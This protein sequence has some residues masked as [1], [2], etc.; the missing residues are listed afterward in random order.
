[1][2]EALM[3]T[4]NPYDGPRI[5]GSVGPA[6]PGVSVRVVAEGGLPA[7]T[8]EPGV[9][10]MTGPNLFSGYW[11]NPEKTAQDHT[12]DGWFISGDIV[13]QDEAG[14]IRIVGRA[15]DLIISGGYNIYPKEVE[16]AIDA[17]NGVLESAVIGLPHPDFGEGVLAV[18]AREPGADPQA[19]AI[20]RALTSQLAAFKRPKRIVVV[21]E[22]PRNAMGKVQKAELRRIYADAF[23]SPPA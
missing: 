18:V 4:S 1:M 15:K 2:T 9:L 10:E 23:A 19:E 13:T 21:D 12:A 6:L 20:G 11:R 5:A 14:V 22:L 8:G 17:L 7:P 3:V 16:L